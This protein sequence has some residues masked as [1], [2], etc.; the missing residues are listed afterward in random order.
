MTA[1]GKVFWKLSN[2]LPIL[3]R[4]KTVLKQIDGINYE[5]DLTEVIDRTLFYVG[6][7]EKYTSACLRRYIEHDMTVFEIGSNIGA[8]TF[9]IAKSLMNG[10]GRL[11]GFEPTTFAFMKL[12]RN[13]SL[14]SFN[15]IVL[16]NIG[17]SDENGVLELTSSQI[18]FKSSWNIKDRKLSR[19]H[20]DKIELMKLDD[21]VEQRNIKRIDFIKMDTDGYELKILN[22]GK[23]S[24]SEF[25]PIMLIEVTEALKRVGHSVKELIEL[26][27]S[28]NYQ[29]FSVEDESLLSWNDVLLKPGDILFRAV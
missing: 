6:E 23:N 15:N 16:E 18:C 17:L 1:L 26:L 22:G 3:I 2:R 4:R 5:L 10:K 12:E 27:K 7:W 11:Y 19:K 20:G 13:W 9:Q 8:H 24:I 28:L 14:N 29:A 25:R 21:Y